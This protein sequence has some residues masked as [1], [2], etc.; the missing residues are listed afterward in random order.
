MKN[1]KPCN[2][3]PLLRAV[4]HPFGDNLKAYETFFCDGK[5]K[6]FGRGRTVWDANG[7]S[8]LGLLKEHIASHLLHMTKEECLEKLPPQTRVFRQVPVSSRHQLQHNQALSELATV[9]ASAGTL[10]NSGD[11]VLT[12]FSRV[13]QIA[14]F[15]KIDAT[16][17]IAKEV[18]QEQP[19]VVI[20]SNFATVAKIVHQKLAEAG[21]IG[22]LL[23]GETPPKKRQGMVDN[24]QEGLSPVF[25][26]T[27]GAGGV[28][29]TL[30]A[31]HTIILLDR[32]WTPG[33]AQQAEDRVRRIGQENPVT[34]IWMVAFNLD[35]Q[36][37]QLIEQKKNTTQAVLAK[38]DH[39]AAIT[40]PKISIFQLLKSVF[41][42]SGAVGINLV[43]P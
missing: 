11:V 14:S 16:V 39:Q 34:S 37:D 43:H 38:G 22:E 9:Y 26:S 30:T 2:L 31:A 32:P 27:F 19:A 15:A 36:I 25:I 1:G 17:A 18:L 23:T 8:N 4:N 3:F 41:G 33:E 40:A 13:R 5:E 7:C 28:G 6:S 35:K 21:W 42:S 20:F 29:L 24:F 10:E 12:A